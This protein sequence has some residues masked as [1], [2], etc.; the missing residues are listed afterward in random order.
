VY[1]APIFLYMV[2][3][4]PVVYFDVWRPSAFEYDKVGSKHNN[5]LLR[6]Q[7]KLSPNSHS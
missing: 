7:Q 4:Y 2:L 6:R 5:P 3:T 1:T